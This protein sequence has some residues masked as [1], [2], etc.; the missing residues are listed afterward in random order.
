MHILIPHSSPA[1][2][3]FQP[4]VGSPA[5]FFLSSLPQFHQGTF[6]C[7]FGGLF[8]GRDH[9]WE[10]SPA[11]A[12]VISSQSPCLLSYQSPQF[13]IPQII[14]LPILCQSLSFAPHNIWSRIWGLTAM[15][16]QARERG[17]H[18]GQPELTSSELRQSRHIPK[19]E[20]TSIS[21]QPKCSV[22]ER[23]GHGSPWMKEQSRKNWLG[24]RESRNGFVWIC[25]VWSVWG[26]SNKGV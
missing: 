21:D 11:H 1:F 2:P 17:P 23:K 6:H 20:P 19:L 5:T 4:T 26:T 24:L 16:I 15:I 12:L 25:W 10:N 13:E 7:S 14:Y 8:Q 18:A 3:G 22:W 9:I